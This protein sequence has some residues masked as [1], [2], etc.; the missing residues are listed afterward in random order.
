MSGG[1]RTSPILICRSDVDA[2]LHRASFYL[3]SSPPQSSPTLSLSVRLGSP[4]SLPRGSSR[5]RHEQRAEQQLARWRIESGF[6]ATKRFVACRGAECLCKRADATAHLGVLATRVG[7]QLHGDGAVFC[8]YIRM[9]ECCGDRFLFIALSA[10]PHARVDYVH[11]GNVVGDA[12][13]AC[14]AEC[15][16]PHVLRF[17][18]RA[19]DPSTPRRRFSFTECSGSGNEDESATQ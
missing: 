14:G 12:V 15:A 7:E 10:L 16:L 11:E 19:P 1:R 17:S 2:P 5:R 18:L 8:T 6:D 13:C 9:P 4:D 3:R